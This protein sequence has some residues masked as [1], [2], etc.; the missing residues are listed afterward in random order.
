MYHLVIL[1]RQLVRLAAIAGQCF[2]SPPKGFGA[3]I[4]VLPKVI[5]RLPGSGHPLALVLVSC[6]EATERRANVGVNDRT[7]I[8]LAP[9]STMLGRSKK[10]LLLARLELLTFG[11]NSLTDALQASAGKSFPGRARTADLKINS[12]TLTTN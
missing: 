9:G 8:T 4:I 5:S 3:L 10:E 12:L 6:R 11:L 7:A 2:G 1:W